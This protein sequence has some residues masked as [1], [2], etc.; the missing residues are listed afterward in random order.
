[1]FSQSCLGYYTLA[2]LTC[3]T[4]YIHMYMYIQCTY[5]VHVLGTALAD[6]YSN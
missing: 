5:S 6:I 1:M 2:V 4:T 3:V